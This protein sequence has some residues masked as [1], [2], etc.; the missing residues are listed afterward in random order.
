MSY[1][2]EPRPD[3]ARLVEPAGKRVLD[4]GCGEG[5]LAAALKEGG[6]ERVVGI[7]L[8]PE[9][10][11]V[12][13]GRLDLVLEGDAA[14][15][16]LDEL[17][18]DF[19]YLVFADSLE[20]MPDPERVLDRLLPLLRPGGRVIVSVPNMRFYAVLGRLLFDRW[21]YSESGVRDRTHLR[22][23]TRRSLERMLVERGLVIERLERNYRLF[24]DQSQIG[25][26]G[27]LATR[28]VQRV[29]GPMVFRDLLAYQFIAVA[30]L[31]RPR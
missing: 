16:A 14:E 15:V 21:E 4:V 3:I 28:F 26:T 24:D 1:F 19:D 22:V 11:A 12:A 27:A 2:G 31:A 20:H 6:A 8:D 30:R 17:P 7:E 10:A 25:R 23:L 13:Q 18:R 5:A 29:A 9:A